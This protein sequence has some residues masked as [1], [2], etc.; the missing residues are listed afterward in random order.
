[1][2][3]HSLRGLPNQ[4]AYVTKAKL[5]PC[6]LRDIPLA[7]AGW[8]PRVDRYGAACKWADGAGDG[9]GFVTIVPFS[10]QEGIFECQL[11]SGF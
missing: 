9:K 3:C 1:M 6:I 8:I 4:I 5:H 2:L 7:R 11:E 10:C